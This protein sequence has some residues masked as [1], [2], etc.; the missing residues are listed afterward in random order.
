MELYAGFDLHSNN[1]VAAVIDQDGKL[2]AR[3]RVQNDPEQ[4]IDFMSPF[5]QNMAGIAVESTFNW[6]WLV[7]LFMDHDYKM[8]LANPTAF[9]QYKGLKHSNDHDDALWLAQMLRL[10]VLP[11]GYIYPKSTRPLRD[12]L[13][14]RSHLVRVRQSILT[15]LQTIIRR[16]GYGLLPSRDIKHLGEDR[17]AGV[18]MNDDSLNLARETSKA[19]IDSITRQIELIEKHILK[20]IK[21]D[22]GYNLLT[23]IPGVGLVLSMTILLE[24]GPISR[25]PGVRNYTSYCR[26]T[27]S[28]WTSNKKRKGSGNKKNGNKHLAWAFSEAAEMSRR[29]NGRILAYY[30][31]KMSR[32]NRMVA[33]G[34]IANKLTKA[35]YYMLRDD[36]PFCMDKLFP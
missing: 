24:T 33:H 17:V 31:K 6:Y 18:D 35:V 30:K 19:V 32:T 1:T 10:G 16:N 28:E 12:L 26:K 25:F 20:R 27:S 11:Q 13:R 2:L 9:Q 23:T 14:K 8:H 34:A 22:S 5:S 36:A 15:S 7:D 3:K 4:L 21:D 29:H